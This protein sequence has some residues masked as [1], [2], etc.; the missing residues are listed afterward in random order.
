MFQFL[1]K[2]QS[3]GSANLLSKYSK[4]FASKDEKQTLAASFGFNS[5]ESFRTFLINLYIQG[6]SLNEK[7]PELKEFT[8]NESSIRL[9]A[10]NVINSKL[11]PTVTAEQC[12]EAYFALTAIWSL[13][14]Q[15]EP[16]WSSCMIV[17]YAYIAGITIGCLLAVE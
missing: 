2:I 3:T 9:A 5:D 7:F 13:Y 17:S 15:Q 8:K 10:R 6:A 16:D 1:K 12:W 14:C 11:K 4:Q